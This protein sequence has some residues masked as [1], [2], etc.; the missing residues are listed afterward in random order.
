MKAKYKKP[1]IKKIKVDT[2][3]SLVMMTDE[4]T[5]PGNPPWSQGI[6]DKKTD[7]PFKAYKA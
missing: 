4:N 1:S 2:D 3:I 5:I 6:E 7:E